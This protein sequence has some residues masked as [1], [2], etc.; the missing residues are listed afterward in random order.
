MKQGVCHLCGLDKELHNSHVMPK[1]LYKRI[2]EKT[3]KMD[4]S[5]KTAKYDTSQLRD[6]LFCR[7]CEDIFKLG[8]DTFYQYTDHSDQ[9]LQILDERGLYRVHHDDEQ[10]I[11]MFV[12]GLL[13]RFHVLNKTNINLG[14]YYDQIKSL[15]LNSSYGELAEVNNIAVYMTRITVD[16][17]KLNHFL[18]LPSHRK[19]NHLNAYVI[20]LLNF[21]VLVFLDKRAPSME[22][23][24]TRLCGESPAVF[25]LPWYR[26]FTRSDPRVKISDLTLLNKLKNEYQT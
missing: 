12:L 5:D 8:E 16:D 11:A 14:P 23:W 10:R 25:E 18:M 2:T 9:H 13:Y 19:I 24:K 22:L 3:I 7:E 6:F 26:S 21:D 15:L 20:G 1:G 17:E 4:F